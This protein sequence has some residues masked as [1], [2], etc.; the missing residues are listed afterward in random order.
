MKMDQKTVSELEKELE[1]AITDV[2]LSLG[3]KRL[4]LLPNQQTFHLMA[5]AALAVYEEAV[6]N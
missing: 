4:P 1:D 3:L 6:E 2:V 5:K